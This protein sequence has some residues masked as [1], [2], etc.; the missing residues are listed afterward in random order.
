MACPGHPDTPLYAHTECPGCQTV[1]L[2]CYI[3][4]NG[5]GDAI[6]NMM[7][8]DREYSDPAKIQSLKEYVQQRYGESIPPYSNEEESVQ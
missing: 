3:S 5:R 2:I 7:L 8:A 6:K 1:N 4:S